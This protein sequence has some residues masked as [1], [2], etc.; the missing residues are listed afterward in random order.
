MRIPRHLDVAPEPTD[1][2]L[3][4]TVAAKLYTADG[5]DL[6]RGGERLRRWS[7]RVGLQPAEWS[8]KSRPGLS[9]FQL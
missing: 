7:F 2:L 8:R 4:G 3:S 9:S 6:L 1:S 5:D